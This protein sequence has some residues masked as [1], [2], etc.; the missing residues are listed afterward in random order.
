MSMKMRILI[1]AIVAG[2]CLGASAWMFRVRTDNN[3]PRGVIRYRWKWGR[4]SEISIDRDRDG[5][6]DVK[7]FYPGRFRDFASDDPPRELWAD[8]NLDGRFDVMWRREDSLIVRRDV[9]DDGILET[10]LRGA[11]AERFKADLTLFK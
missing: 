10:E 9:D 4:A 8:Q 6:A 3:D 11:D 7:V 5:R 2:V 1:I